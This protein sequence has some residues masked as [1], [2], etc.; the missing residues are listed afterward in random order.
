MLLLKKM[1][2]YKYWY[3]PSSLNEIEN[4]SKLVDRLKSDGNK[5]HYKEEKEILR[6]MSIYFL[7]IN[8]IE[9]EHIKR[10]WEV[11]KERGRKERAEGWRN[12]RLPKESSGQH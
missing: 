8:N 9:I 6:D 3:K 7:N 4:A 2:Q 5:D 1:T 10:F 11:K 12:N